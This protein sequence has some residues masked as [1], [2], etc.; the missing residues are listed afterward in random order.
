ME[1]RPTQVGGTGRKK[2]FVNKDSYVFCM[3]LGQIL[4]EATY[5]T[6]TEIHETHE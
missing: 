6:H 5:E 2:Q 4:D 1:Q 3:S